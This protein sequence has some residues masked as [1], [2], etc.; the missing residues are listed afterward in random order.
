[1]TVVTRDVLERRMQGIEAQRAGATWDEAA[2]IAGMSTSGFRYWAARMEGRMVG[3]EGPR[4]LQPGERWCA[5][6][7]MRT[8]E[9]LHCQDCRF[10][11]RTGMLAT[12]SAMELVLVGEA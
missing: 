12:E 4:P 3:R 5:R 11:L 1:M 8:T 7:G 6:C 10:E 2:E 9:P